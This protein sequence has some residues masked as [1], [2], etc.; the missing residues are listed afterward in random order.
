ML[1]TSGQYFICMWEVVWSS[2]QKHGLVTTDYSTGNFW[3]QIPVLPLTTQMTLEKS[4]ISLCVSFPVC[5]MGM[6]TLPYLPGRDVV[7]NVYAA[8]WR[9][10]VLR[11]V[12]SSQAAHEGSYGLDWERKSAHTE[13]LF[14]IGFTAEMVG[15][16]FC[17]GSLES[18]LHHYSFSQRFQ[19]G[20]AYSSSQKS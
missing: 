2:E 10:S 6:I 4:L 13:T 7:S 14:G 19:L 16:D 17:K 18:R 3:D 11:I 1:Y 9:W 8:L 20:A 12:L 15:L 5:M